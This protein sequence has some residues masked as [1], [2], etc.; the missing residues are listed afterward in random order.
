MDSGG[1]QSEDL[2][3][4][5]QELVGIMI[6]RHDHISMWTATNRR[7]GDLVHT[8]K[9]GIRVTEFLPEPSGGHQRVLGPYFRRARRKQ[10]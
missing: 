1:N 2:E 6:P 3:K 7:K 4:K 8:Q 5:A 9:K 10:K